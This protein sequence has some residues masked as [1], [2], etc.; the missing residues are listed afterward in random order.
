MSPILR[1]YTKVV[2][3]VL[4]LVIILAAAWF[5]AVSAAASKFHGEA[6]QFWGDHYHE[7]VTT[8]KIDGMMGMMIPQGGPL[9]DASAAGVCGFSGGTFLLPVRLSENKQPGIVEVLCPDLSVQTV[10]IELLAYAVI[11]KAI[12]G[13]DI[14]TP[15]EAHLRALLDQIE[16]N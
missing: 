11:H 10:E 7:G 15:D 9:I 12:T 8:H 5:V 13:F 1:T 14:E 16:S 6:I 3:I 4:A 2:M